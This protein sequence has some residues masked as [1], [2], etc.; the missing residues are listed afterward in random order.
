[1]K[2][3]ERAK[4]LRIAL[5][6]I[7][8]QHPEINDYN[9]VWQEEFEWCKEVM[10]LG[11]ELAE[12]EEIGKGY[13]R[14]LSCTSLANYTLSNYYRDLKAKKT[15]D[16]VA[17]LWGVPKTSLRT[18]VIDKGGTYKPT[19]GKYLGMLITKENNPYEP[20]SKYTKKPRGLDD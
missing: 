8:D 20:S 6:D 7:L 13:D 12:L 9:D 19:R 4:E 1:M 11:K 14:K 18:W 10:E 17:D 3:R 16:A 15:H 2:N 5:H